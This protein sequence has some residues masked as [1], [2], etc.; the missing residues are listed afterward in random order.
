MCL[1]FV[2]KG[3]GEN[4]NGYNSK[5]ECER[6]I[7]GKKLFDFLKNVFIKILKDF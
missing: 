3:C 1:S 4:K 2:Y 7:P 6:C 5:D